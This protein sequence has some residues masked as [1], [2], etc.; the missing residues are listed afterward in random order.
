MGKKCIAREL[1]GAHYSVPRYRRERATADTQT[2]PRR[3]TLDAEQQQVARS[4]LD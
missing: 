2:R 1:G 4:L 3:M